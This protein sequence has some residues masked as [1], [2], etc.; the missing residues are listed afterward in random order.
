MTRDSATALNSLIDAADILEGELSSDQAWLKSVAMMNA[1][2]YNALNI[3]EVERKSGQARWFRSSMKSQWLTDYV[4]Q[5]FVSM[6]PL[7]LAACDDQSQIRMLDGK[8]LGIEDDSQKMLDYRD[9]ITNWGYRTLDV[10]VFSGADIGYVKGVTVSQSDAEPVLGK[11]HRLLCAMISHAVNAPLSL[12]SPGAVMLSSDRLSTR[13]IDALSF[14]ASGL[15]N[16]AI[17]WKMSIAEVTVRMHLASARRKLG[18]ATREEAVALA[19]RSG[20]LPL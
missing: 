9:Q 12:S 6:D 8:V 19:I 3:V 18:A 10:Q 20:Q 4:E 11:H 14:L 5:D 16:D 15:R 17:A 7:I 1:N 2:G 13:E